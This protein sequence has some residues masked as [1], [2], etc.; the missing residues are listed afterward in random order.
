MSSVPTK[1]GAVRDGRSS[2]LKGTGRARLLDAAQAELRER[3]YEG[4][5]L[6][7]IARRAGLTKGAVYWSFRDK[8]DLFRA[9]VDERIDARVRE[10]MAITETSPADIATAPAVSAGLARL[11]REQPELV[12]ILFE[13]WAQA[14]RDPDLRPAYVRRQG[15][16]REALARAL[17]ARHDTTGVP[18]AYPAERLATIVLALGAGLAMGALVEAEAITDDLLGDALQLLYQG[19]EFRARQTL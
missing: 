9:L 5:S 15:A 7:A 8:Q 19:L 16:L 10:L 13:Q 12:L 3:G 18:L 6:Q 14:V 17:R 2:E 4:T 11:V 1:A